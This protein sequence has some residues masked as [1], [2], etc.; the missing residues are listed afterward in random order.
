MQSQFTQAKLVVQAEKVTT[1]DLG[2]TGREAM[3]EDVNLNRNKVW[4]DAPSFSAG[5]KLCSASTQD[6]WG[7]GS[8]CTSSTQNVL[9][10]IC[11]HNAFQ[12]AE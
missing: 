2:A 11:P 7:Q 1:K 10:Y 9:K 4:G 6:N 8:S 3:G 12:I 5:K